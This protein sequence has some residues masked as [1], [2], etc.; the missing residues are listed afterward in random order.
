MLRMA[1]DEVEEAEVDGVLMRSFL[2]RSIR[3]GAEMRNKERVEFTG[4]NDCFL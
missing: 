4:R 2:N 1:D 3:S